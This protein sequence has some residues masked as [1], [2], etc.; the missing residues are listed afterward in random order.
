MVGEVNKDIFSTYNPIINFLFFM[1]AVILGMFFVHPAL[2][3]CSVLLSF[4]Y[5]ITIRKSRSLKFLAGMIPLFVVLSAINPLFNTNGETVLFT[6]FGG[7]PYTLEALFYG[8][9]IAAMFV[10]ILTW[11]AC[12]NAVMT[13]DKFYSKLSA[14]SCPDCG[15][16]KMHRKSRRCRYEKR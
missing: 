9:A 5:Y 6:Y 1:G 4:A 11:F 12:Y 7:R 8:I 13:S 2:L 15:S 3:A 16:Q 14:K 10:S